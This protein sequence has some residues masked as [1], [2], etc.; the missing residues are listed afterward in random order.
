MKRPTE[1]AAFR[2][3]ELA[4]RLGN[5]RP[6]RFD[7]EISAKATEVARTRDPLRRYTL[8]LAEAVAQK[9]HLPAGFVA[10]RLAV[11]EAALQVKA[12]KE[13]RYGG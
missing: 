3:I 2:R 1:D 9:L 8:T 7:W 6:T 10:D 11:V 4:A 12:L 5:Q 13:F